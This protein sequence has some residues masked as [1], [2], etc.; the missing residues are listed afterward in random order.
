[1]ETLATITSLDH[2]FRQSSQ[3]WNPV[4]SSNFHHGNAYSPMECV[5][6]SVHHELLA[7]Q[8]LAR[9]VNR[10]ATLQ[11]TTT[12]VNTTVVLLQRER[13][14]VD[15][16]EIHLTLGTAFALVLSETSSALLFL[17]SSRGL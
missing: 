9:E 8:R 10:V 11:S 1:M 12:L 15:P 3:T 16:L 6:V 14:V 17:S 2:P 13:T 7:E 5:N 4:L